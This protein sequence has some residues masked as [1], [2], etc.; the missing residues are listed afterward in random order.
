LPWFFKNIESVNGGGFM[1][2]ETIIH[3]AKIA[4]NGVPSFV[5]AVAIGNGKIIGT[6]KN[7]EI[8]R[9]RGPETK[10]I[11]GIQPRSASP[12]TADVD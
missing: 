9:Q 5:E 1:S 12:F 11:D 10:V 2:A 3:N 8:L 7:D 6:G 4:A